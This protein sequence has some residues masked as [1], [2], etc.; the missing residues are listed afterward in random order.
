[1]E[2]P[3]SRIELKAPANFSA[4]STNFILAIQAI[5]VAMAPRIPPRLFHRFRIPGFEEPDERRADGPGRA[6]ATAGAATDAAASRS[7]IIWRRISASIS[8]E[9][10]SRAVPTR[11]V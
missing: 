4:M 11:P 10:L 5:A 6:P 2:P 7:A 1:M 9:A 3:A 8:A